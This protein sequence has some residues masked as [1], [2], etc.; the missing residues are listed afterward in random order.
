MAPTLNLKEVQG[1]RQSQVEAWPAGPGEP[2]LAPPHPIRRR[3]CPAP[4]SSRALPCSCHGNGKRMQELRRSRVP[5]ARAPWSR[6][7]G[8]SGVPEPEA[9]TKAREPQSVPALPEGGGRVTH[10]AKPYLPLRDRLSS[11]PV[12]P[13]RGTLNLRKPLGV[14]PQR[15]QS[16]SL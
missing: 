6:S 2:D 13:S 10:P 9:A 5:V 14:F 8:R 16:A 4:S 15:W 11:V 12:P 7:S 1:S 3:T